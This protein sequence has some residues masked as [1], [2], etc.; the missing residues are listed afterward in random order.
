MPISKPRVAILTNVVPKYRE[1]FYHLVTSNPNYSVTIFCQPHI[2]GSNLHSIHEKFASHVRV[3]DYL[4]YRGEEV[5]W[6]RLPWRHII[7]NYDIVVVDGNPRSISQSLLAFTLRMLGR[8]VVVWSSVYSYRDSDLRR[9]IRLLWWKQFNSFYLYTEAD[10]DELKKAGFQNAIAVAANN[11]LDQQ[12]IEAQKRLWTAD[13]LRRWQQEAGIADRQVILSSGRLIPKNRYDLVARAMPAVVKRHPKVLWCLIG[14]G[15]VEKELESIISELGIGEHVR[16]LGP[17]YEEAQLAPWFLSSAVFVHPDAIGL[18]LMHAFG[19]GVPVI[20]HDNWRHHN[21]EYAVFKP[22]ENGESFRE[23]DVDHLAEV[24]SSLLADPE[25]R[26]RMS[27]SGE[28]IAREHS[29]TDIMAQQFSHLVQL[30]S[31]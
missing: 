14:D 24:I 12:S 3:V 6:Q 20:T 29:N 22:G 15:P 31:A 10:V 13:S 25:R 4:A 9:R 5:V 2:A 30:L 8:K 7:R 19:Y 28:R 16:M 17:I 11:G 23:G 21:P 18:S 26:Q 1:R 27:V